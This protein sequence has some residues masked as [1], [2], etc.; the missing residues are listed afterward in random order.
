MDMI[1]TDQTIA[2]HKNA[3]ISGAWDVIVC[4]AGPSGI[5]AAVCAARLGQKTLLLER[6]GAVGGCLTLGHVTTI[7]GS[8]AKGGIRDEILALL[9]SKSSATAIESE[10][11]KGLL[12]DFIQA[13]GVTFRLQTPVVDTVVSDGAATGVIAQTQNGLVCF[14]ARRVIDATGD[15]YVAAM[16]GCETML[17]RDGDGLLQPVSLMY[18]VD[19]VDKASTLFCKHEEHYTTLPDGREY[20]SLCKQAEKDGVLP[21]NVTIVRLYATG[22]PGERLVNATQANGINPLHDGDTERAEVLLRSQIARINQFLRAQIPGFEH[23]RTR[24]SASTLGV[25]ETRRIKGRYILTAEDLIEGRRFEDCVVHRA[26]FAID[27]HNPSGGG[28]SETDG[29]PHTTKPYDIPMRALQPLHIENLIVC[30]RCISGTHRAHASYRVMNIVMA[31]GQ[32]AGVMAAVSNQTETPVSEL[33]YAD[34][35]RALLR[36]GCTLHSAD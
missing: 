9:S 32:A 2:Y 4:G 5:A 15:G 23:I 29:R 22:S 18:T 25:R 34:V 21:K 17:G 14:G 19:G 13:N 1:K 26:S 7:M 28:Q 11:A 12:V 10:D 8:V 3:P 24:G 27:I 36:Q 20:I 6:Y 35:K 33:D 31:M 16:A 30:G